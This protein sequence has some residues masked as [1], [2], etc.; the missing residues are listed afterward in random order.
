MVI[1]IRKA[2]KEDIQEINTIYSLGRLDEERLTESK[3]ALKMRNFK[4]NKKERIKELTEG[5]E[6]KKEIWLV[7]Q[8]E[9][10]ILGFINAA[11]IDEEVC[12]LDRIYIL[13]N[14][15]RKKVGTKLFKELINIVKKRNFERMVSYIKKGNKKSQKFHQSFG[16]TSP[17]IRME[18]ELK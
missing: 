6:S 17:T 13:K 15:R 10:T 16:F 2:K 4:K 5:I 7:A 8:E 9:N 3:D 18:K 14:F 11:E 1:K 12:V